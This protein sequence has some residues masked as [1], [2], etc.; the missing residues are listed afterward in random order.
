LKKRLSV[1]LV[2]ASPLWVAILEVLFLRANL[3]RWVIIGL[4][5][6]LIGGIIVVVPQDLTPTDG[7]EPLLGSI[8]ATV[9]GIAVAIYYV[10]GR[11]LRAKLS[12]LP[13]IWLVYSCAAIVLVATIFIVKIP[14]TGYQTSGY[15]AVLGMALIP[16]LLG[17]SSFN[18]AL[19]YFPATYV[20]ISAQLEPVFSAFI[21]FVYFH[22]TP[23]A[24]QILGSIIVLA[25]VIIASLKGINST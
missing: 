4:L 12:L 10:I 6:S 3:G 13:Y 21:A 7:R 5:I 8:L 22:E 11:K 18:F 23:G 16:Q 24:F 17:H 20:G 1:V 14:I 2:S 9:G 15:I 19:K 25:G